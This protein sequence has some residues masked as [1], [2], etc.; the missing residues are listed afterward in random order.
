M[1]VVNL[2]SE[3]LDDQTFPA[4]PSSI[5]IEK[6]LFRRNVESLEF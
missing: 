6:D 4:G 2:R 3:I 5:M 1:R